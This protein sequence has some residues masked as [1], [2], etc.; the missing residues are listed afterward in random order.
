METFCKFY[1]VFITRK[2]ASKHNSEFLLF[3]EYVSN[4]SL[5]YITNMTLRA[6]SSPIVQTSQDANHMFRNNFMH[7]TLNFFSF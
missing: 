5:I 3:N 2:E 6:Q 4:L 1:F 7:V